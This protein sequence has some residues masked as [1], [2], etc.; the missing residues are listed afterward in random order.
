MIK[1]S[2]LL[3]DAELLIEEGGKVYST[4]LVNEVVDAYGIVVKVCLAKDKKLTRKEL[5]E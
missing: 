2:D 5:F 4:K 3:Y 1:L